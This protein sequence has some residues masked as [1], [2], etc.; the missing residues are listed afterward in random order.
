MYQEALEAL[1][2]SESKS[3]LEQAKRI[4]FDDTSA[5]FQL[6]P[7]TPGIISEIAIRIKNRS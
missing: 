7:K 6:S 5:I 3:T 1:I 2:S 4:G